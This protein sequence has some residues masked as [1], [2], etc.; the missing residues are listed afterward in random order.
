LQK[1][2]Q[3][4][5]MLAKSGK[6]DP[7]IGRDEEIRR[8][9]QILS[10]RTK[11]NPVLIGDPGVGKTAIAEG[12]AQ[13]IVSGDVPSNLK[14]KDLISL[15]IGS[16]LAGAKYRGEFEERLKSILKEVE[17]SDGKII[18]FVDELHTIVGAGASEG[19]IDAANMLKPLL[20]RGKLHLVGATTIDEYRKYIEKDAA[21]E[22]RLQPIVVG[23]PTIEDT[24]AI[25]RGL[26]EKYE[27]HHGVRITDNALIAAAKLSDR[28][29][30]DRFLPDKAI[31]LID[32]ATSSLK[33]EIDSMPLELDRLNRKIRQYEIDREALKK[34]KDAQAKERLKETDKK[35]ADLEEE[36]RVLDS[37][38]QK[39]KNLI[40]N[41]RN[42]QEKLEEAKYQET[43]TER[44]GDFQ[45]AAEVKYATIPA[46]Q[47]ELDLVTAELNSIDPSKRM[48]RE[49]VSADDIAR[50]VA[51]WTGVPVTRLLETEKDKLIHLE[52]EL[53]A[54]VIGQSEAIS[55]IA[56]MVRKS[57]AGIATPTKPLGSFM[58]LGPTGVGKTELTKAL[59]DVLFNDSSAMVRIDMS[60]YMESH[61][62]ARLI[63]APPG[64]VG[65]EEG[66]QLTEAVRRHP[67]S[68]VLFDEI[69]KAHPEVFNVLL[70][71]LDDGR[72]TD[73]K[74]KVVNF[75]NTIIILTSNIGSDLIQAWDGKNKSVLETEVMG[76]VKRQFRP[77]FL[78]RLDRIIIF[79]RLNM[80]DMKDIVD[81]QLT[82]L[83]KLL[84]ARDLKVEFSN[85]L[86]TKLAQEGYDP[87]FGARPLRRLID[88][89]IV[90]EISLMI[91][92]E[93]IHEGDLIKVDIDDKNKVTIVN[94]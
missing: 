16:L 86:K 6:L 41:V 46:L 52:D 53:A 22:R 94:K 89:L 21:L 81:I 87:A 18:L 9:M 80:D 1:Y 83:S 79:N 7:V 13:R 14:N 39:E 31:D 42:I 58:F 32:E 37:T 54:R 8:V 85:K 26:K 56:K 78:N 11:N 48:L 35:I 23:E 40:M 49:E 25:L 64:Y 55:V 72:M 77:E 2:G 62:V 44:E 27:V 24:I 15:E 50:V 45:K 76:L 29:I 36:A 47:K 10:R 71:V 34:E 88:E 92:E 73:G 4:L 30:S 43:I 17:S 66:G 63:G 51:R 28:Y 84:G 69:E 82:Q 12:L 59:A 75:Q 5:T 19:A 91:I 68:V 33:M 38:W 57:R 67:Y 3:N 70:Q 65:Y 61:S 60:E 74:G 20:A 90:D 93:K